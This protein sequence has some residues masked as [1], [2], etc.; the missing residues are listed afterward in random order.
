[1]KWFYSSMLIS[2]LILIVYGL[3]P[4]INGSFK[5]NK[6]LIAHAYFKTEDRNCEVKCDS[7]IE[8]HSDQLYPFLPN[9]NGIYVVVERSPYVI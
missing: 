2:E 3:F 6:F 5:R 1:M 7:S 4:L 9:I 8:Y